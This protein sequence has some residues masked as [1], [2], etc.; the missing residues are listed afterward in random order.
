MAAP[1]M[2][3]LA[4][5]AGYPSYETYLTSEHWLEFR[6]QHLQKTCFCCKGTHW[7]MCL[8]HLTYERLNC[9]KP[10]DVVTLCEPCHEEVHAICKRGTALANA[11]IKLANL[12]GNLVKV[13]HVEKANWVPLHGLKEFTERFDRVFE[14]LTKLGWIADQTGTP[15]GKAKRLEVVKQEQGLLLWN[16]SA[17]IAEIKAA[18]TKKKKRRIKT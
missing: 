14:K 9:E 17:Y 12:N 4:R 15:S 2:D 18:R 6:Q 8:H 7:K 13:E 3:Q 1:L 11:H 10:S 16:K 5:L